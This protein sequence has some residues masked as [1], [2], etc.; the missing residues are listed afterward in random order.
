VVTAYHGHR[1]SRESGR[2]CVKTVSLKPDYAGWV[3]ATWYP[4]TD[5]DL[6]SQ[7]WTPNLTSGGSGIEV[8]WSHIVGTTD[9]SGSTV[10]MWINSLFWGIV[11]FNTKPLNGGHVWQANLDLN[12]A[13]TQGV[14][15][16]RGRTCLAKYAGANGYSSP[17]EG[18]GPFVS[19]PHGQFQGPKLRLDVTSFAQAWVSGHV[20]NK[21][22]ILESSYPYVQYK[23]MTMSSTCLT[24]FLSPRLD[25]TYYT[26]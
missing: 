10:T 1:E 9:Q 13:R 21:G 19:G 25:V 5:E 17:L 26:W 8:G 16:G 2:V 12:A 24:P 4:R 23:G 22:I 14:P 3:D 7:S 18:S 15:G 11:H 6:Y 20:P